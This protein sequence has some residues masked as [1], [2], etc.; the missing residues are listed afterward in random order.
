MRGQAWRDRRRQDSKTTVEAGAGWGWEAQKCRTQAEE[1]GWM[2]RGSKGGLGKQI[3][4]VG[5]DRCKT[6]RRRQVRQPLF[7][8]Q[9]RATTRER[10][11]TQVASPPD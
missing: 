1:R 11:P 8:A 4:K 9:E 6:L 3:G 10:L 5:E 7:L 2:E